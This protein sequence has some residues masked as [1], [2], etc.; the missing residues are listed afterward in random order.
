[1]SRQEPVFYNLEFFGD[2]PFWTGVGDNTTRRT[3]LM[4]LPN[5]T[6]FLAFGVFGPESTVHFVARGRLRENLGDFTA[7]MVE[8]GAT[9]ELYER[10]PLPWAVV[11]R[12]SKDLPYHQEVEGPK[13][14]PVQ[15]FAGFGGGADADASR[16]VAGVSVE[17]SSEQLTWPAVDSPRHVLILPSGSENQF[18]AL[19]V[20]LPRDASDK[21]RFVF[22][23]RGNV[24]NDLASFVLRMKEDGAIITLRDW[25]PQELAYLRLYLKAHFD[26]FFLAAD[27]PQPATLVAFAGAGIQ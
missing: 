2:A 19:G 26:A 8:A 12:Y 1:M 11:K 4:P 17:L 22:A 9:V 21:H 14:P 24:D 16:W 5:P 10:P 13:N 15:G 20:C 7:R 18:L 23:A 3:F 27:V 6:E 25:P